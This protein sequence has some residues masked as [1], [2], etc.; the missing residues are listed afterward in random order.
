MDWPSPGTALSRQTR[1]SI[2][3][4]GSLHFLLLRCS[5]ADYSITAGSKICVITAGARQRE[6]ET[7]LSLVQRNVEI[8]KGIVPKLVHY[9]PETIIMIVSNPG[10]ER[11][12][13]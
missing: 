2:Q 6:G 4:S 7:R 5:I 8:F 12:G 11:F 1:V 10:E 3:C 9:S 13:F